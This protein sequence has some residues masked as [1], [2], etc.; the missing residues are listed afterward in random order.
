M[1]SGGSMRQRAVMGLGRRVDVCWQA[2]GRAGGRA[3]ARVGAGAGARGFV[4]ALR[5]GAA[6]EE[7]LHVDASA[8]AGE[9]G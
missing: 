2:G 5:N 3:C 9:I 7:D 8:V 4:G 1:R 6:G